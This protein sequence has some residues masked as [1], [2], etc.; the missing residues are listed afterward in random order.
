MPNANVLFLNQYQYSALEGSE[1]EKVEQRKPL[2]LLPRSTPPPDQ[3]AK[4]DESS[5]DAPKKTEDEAK[6][7][8]ENTLK[9]FLS[10]RDMTE[11]LENV[12]ELEPCYKPLFVTEF[13]N[14]SMEMKQS[15]VDSIGEVFKRILSENILTV[16]EFEAGFSDPLEFLPDTAIDVP[17]AY[18]YAAQL[19]IAAGMDAKA[20]EL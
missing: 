18:K 14:Q 7:S 1:P 5:T 11:L 6:R 19:L 3:T 10:L 16:E 20:D 8:I 2:R 13:V 12:K 4:A 17:N 9:E 15:D